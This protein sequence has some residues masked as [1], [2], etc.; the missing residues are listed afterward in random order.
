M[1]IDFPQTVPGVSDDSQADDE[2][3]GP[4]GAPNMIWM[5][6]SLLLI[7]PKLLLRAAG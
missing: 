3:A 2:V 7:S 4:P 5:E 1:Y 6:L